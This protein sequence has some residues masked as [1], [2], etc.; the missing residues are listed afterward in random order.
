MTGDP[1]VVTMVLAVIVFVTAV[2]TVEAASVDD[3]VLVSAGNV[4]VMIVL[5]VGPGT[6]CVVVMVIAGLVVVQGAPVAVTTTAVPEAA[7]VTVL[8]TSE[9]WLKDEQK[10]LALR[11]RRTA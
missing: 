6:F 1:V 5:A 11:A 4:T 7:D 8:V 10:A 2:R 3:T 9:M